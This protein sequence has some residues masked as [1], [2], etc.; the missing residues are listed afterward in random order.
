[1]I[2]SGIASSLV[3]EVGHQAAA[4]LDLVDSLRPEL[5]ARQQQGGPEQV[6]WQM[7]GTLDFGNRGG[8]LGRCPGRRDLDTGLMAV[9][10]LPRA[11][12]FRV[13]VDDPHPFPWARVKLSCALGRAL[14]RDPQWGRLSRLWDS[15]YPTAGLDDAR[16]DYQFPLCNRRCRNHPGPPATPA[17]NASRPIAAASAGAAPNAL[18]NVCV[19]C[20]KHGGLNPP[21]CSRQNRR[22]P[23]P[24]SAR[25]GQM[26]PFHPRRKARR[27]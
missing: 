18:H 3:H 11:F 9:V 19:A 15:F 6:A 24:S 8:L 16:R 1:M 21:E 14:F 13:N 22:L 23:L 2:G 25:R 26:K 17:H 20:G 5:Q 12:V 7:C 4:L 27:G 10:S